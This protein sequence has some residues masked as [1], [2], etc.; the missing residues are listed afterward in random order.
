MRLDSILQQKTSASKPDMQHI[1]PHSS[2]GEHNKHTR[3]TPNGMA[4]SEQGKGTQD[5]TGPD[6]H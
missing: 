5:R 2:P 3:V 4:N 1:Q 6:G